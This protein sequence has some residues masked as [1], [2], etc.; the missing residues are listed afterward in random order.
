MIEALPK[1]PN[2]PEYIEVLKHEIDDKGDRVLFTLQFASP[3]THDQ[4][5]AYF[6][7]PG[8][9]VWT[10][11]TNKLSEKGWADERGNYLGNVIETSPYPSRDRKRWVFRYELKKRERN[12]V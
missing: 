2:A 6:Q 5:D 11:I 4:I 12:R 8:S 10:V 9:T 7:D 3:V 1:L